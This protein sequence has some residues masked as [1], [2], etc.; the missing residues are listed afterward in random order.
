MNNPWVGLAGDPP[1]VLSSDMPW[2]ASADARIRQP[3]RRTRLDLL[4]EPFLGDPFDCRAVLLNGNPGVAGDEL[5]WHR[6]RDFRQALID[7]LR[8]E[9]RTR[10]VFLDERFAAS[11]GGRWW[12]SRLRE[13]LLTVGLDAVARHVFVAESM[14]Y[15][16]E[17]TRQIAVPSQAY[18]VWLVE[19]AMR[20]SLP[21]IWIRGP[22]D[23]LAAGLSDYPYLFRTSNPQVAHISRTNCPS[24]FSALV[25]ALRNGG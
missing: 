25:R 14:P 6:Q 10:F 12:L 16:T 19:Q 20:R 13:L 7:N 24:G 11:P 8:H 23:K 15:H 2:V 22:W 21:V 3:T 9:A 4:P 5:T 1:Y 17:A 18:T